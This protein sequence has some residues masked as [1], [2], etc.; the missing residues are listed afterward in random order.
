MCCKNIALC[1]RQQQALLMGY[2]EIILYLINVCGYHVM[3][4][5]CAYVRINIVLKFFYS[6]KID[7]IL[8]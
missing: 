6:R 2:S 8:V 7:E 1:N 3:F 4:V 5:Q